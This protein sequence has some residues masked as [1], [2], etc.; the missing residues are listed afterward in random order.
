MKIW[1]ELFV[2]FLS[3]SRVF[4]KFSLFSGLKPKKSACET[5]E[6]GV[7]KGLRPVLFDMGCNNLN[8]EYVKI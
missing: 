6:I 2:S 8:N 3:I 7:L 5:A 4:D 1:N